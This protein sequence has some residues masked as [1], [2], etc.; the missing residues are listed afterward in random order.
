ML[1]NYWRWIEGLEENCVRARDYD[2]VCV[3]TGIGDCIC[4]QH[5][6]VAHDTKATT[7]ERL[8]G[9][10]GFVLIEIELA[11]SFLCMY[12]LG[13]SIYD[14]MINESLRKVHRAEA[15][16]YIDVV[17]YN[18]VNYTL[19]I[20]RC[21]LPFPARLNSIKILSPSFTRRIVRTRI[22]L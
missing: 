20:F 1:T 22:R 10:Y 18:V 4:L 8:N 19:L 21:V 13:S 6:L 3:V 9:R 14:C 5:D 15:Q 12:Q 16:A 11:L 7:G 2:T 17:N